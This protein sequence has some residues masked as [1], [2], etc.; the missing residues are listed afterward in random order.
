MKLYATCVISQQKFLV[1]LRA[2]ELV[3]DVLEVELLRHE[4]VKLL[5]KPLLSFQ[6][7]LC[8]GPANQKLFSEHNES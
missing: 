5:L 2:E 6:L 1:G 3:K 4:G 8:F 7:H